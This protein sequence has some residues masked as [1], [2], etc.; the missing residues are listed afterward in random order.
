MLYI[1]PFLSLPIPIPIP[2]LKGKSR[3]EGKELNKDTYFI[4][5]VFKYYS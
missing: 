1:C 4:K 2:P 5:I 3:A